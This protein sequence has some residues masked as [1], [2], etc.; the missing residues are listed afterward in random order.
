MLARF[1]CN[2]AVGILL[3]YFPTIVLFFE[4]GAILF[5]TA[6]APTQ[7]PTK[8]YRLRRLQFRLRIS[9]EVPSE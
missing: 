2:F 8:L 6:P 7:A 5:L 1:F 3:S 4:A 9:A